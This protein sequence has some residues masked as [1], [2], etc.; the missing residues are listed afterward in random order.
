[1]LAAF[2]SMCELFTLLDC[3]AVESVIFSHFG[4]G[5]LWL[6]VMFGKK[7]DRMSELNENEYEVL[8]ILWDAGE[9]KPAE[10]QT[11]FG[12]EIENA[13]LRSVL[14]ICWRKDSSCER[15]MAKHLS[16]AP[17]PQGNAVCPIDG[18]DGGDLYRWLEGRFD[19]G[20]SAAR[21]A[22]PGRAG[23]IAE[24]REPKRLRREEANSWNS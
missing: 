4:G 21:E 19:S 12:W 16:T 20:T 14:Q 13:T 6:H 5:M 7:D 10:I 23:D 9:L 18:A 1:M 22:Q 2:S 24:D 11:E 3:L 8:R 17:Q 15:K